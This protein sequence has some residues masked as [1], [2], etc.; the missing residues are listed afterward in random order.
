M[1][2]FRAAVIG[3]GRTASLLEDDPLRA[4]PCSHMGHYRRSSR[5]RVVA[6]ADTDAERRRLF[7]ERWRVRR[8]YGDYQ[9]MLSAERPDVVSLT[10]YAPERFAMYK[11]CIESGVRAVWIEKAIATSLT[12][13]KSMVQ[14]AKRHGI[15]HWDFESERTLDFADFHN[16]GHINASG[17]RKFEAW[18][19]S[20]L[21]A[22]IEERA[23]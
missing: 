19:L 6:G 1:T 13:A 9:E 16:Y 11:A 12:E 15:E 20:G 23:G 17:K 2:T 18:F 10:A 3:C 22:L 8:T 4:K 7:E 14:L 5:I 21:G